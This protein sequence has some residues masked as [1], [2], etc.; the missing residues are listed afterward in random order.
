MS[1]EDEG[2]G[3]ELAL[4]LCL[5]AAGIVGVCIIANLFATYYTLVI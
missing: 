3:V 1:D 4:A 5:Y 2:S